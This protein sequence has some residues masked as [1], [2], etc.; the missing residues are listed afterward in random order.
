MFR[1][2][3]FSI[4]ASLHGQCSEI[5]DPEIGQ[6]G[7]QHQASHPSRVRQ[8][9]FVKMASSIFLVGGTAG[10]EVVLPTGEARKTGEVLK[11]SPVYSGLL[12]MMI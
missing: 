9:T 1:A 2:V 10:P 8:V 5:D 6:A 12:I 4:E 3:N 7:R 11:T